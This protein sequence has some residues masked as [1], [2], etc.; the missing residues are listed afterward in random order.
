MANETLKF[1]GTVFLEILLVVGLAAEARKE[2][3]E[4]LIS[5]KYKPRLASKKN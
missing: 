1:V 5:I 4:N 2:H 3:G